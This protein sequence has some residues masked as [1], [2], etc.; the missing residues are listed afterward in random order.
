MQFHELE[1]PSPFVERE[2]PFSYID[3]FVRGSREE[4]FLART[5]KK[6]CVGLIADPDS[7]GAY[8]AHYLTPSYC[9]PDPMMNLDISFFDLERAKA[10]AISL[11]ASWNRDH[12]GKKELSNGDAK[13]KYIF[14]ESSPLNYPQWQREDGMVMSKEELVYCD[15]SMA[16][17]LDV[18]N[19]VDVDRIIGAFKKAQQQER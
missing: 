19:L 17:L 7:L 14:T 9:R 6:F 11:L 13:P 16:R 1:G 10:F 15:R 18:G 12:F 2:G 3:A 5:D 4:I 8:V